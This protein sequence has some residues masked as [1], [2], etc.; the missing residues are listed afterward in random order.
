[1]DSLV[2]HSLHSA[3]APRDIPHD[4]IVQTIYRGKPFHPSTDWNDAMLAAERFGL[5]NA[6]Y[7]GDGRWGGRFLQPPVSDQ[8][9]WFVGEWAEHCQ[10]TG[11]WI[12]RAPTGPLAICRAILKLHASSAPAAVP[13]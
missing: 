5:W 1:M 3:L 6:G 7:S 13:E 4:R 10:E 11:E 8:Y 2:A 9:Q 12:S